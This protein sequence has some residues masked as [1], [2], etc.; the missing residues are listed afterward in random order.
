MIKVFEL[1]WS[2]EQVVFVPDNDNKEAVP[3]TWGR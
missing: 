2:F 3:A 1:N